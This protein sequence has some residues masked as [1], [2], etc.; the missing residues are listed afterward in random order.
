MQ[1]TIRIPVAN[2]YLTGDLFKPQTKP[3]AAFLACHG[4]TSSNK[5]YIELCRIL[6]K[7]EILA[8]AVNLRG[9]GDSPFKLEEFSRQNHLD[10][11]LAAYDFL[12]SQNGPGKK[13]F[14]LGKSYSGYLSA[15]AT[16]FRKIDYLILSHPALY[17]DREFNTSNVEFIKKEP[18]GFRNRKETVKC[19]RALKA[20][21]QYKNPVL[22]ILSEKDTEVPGEVTD[23]YIKSAQRNPSFLTN[24]I[25]KADHSLT[26][27]YWRQEFNEKVVR[28]VEISL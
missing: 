26:Q 7:K 12:K 9:H 21:S 10:D 2:Q 13:I 17:P 4:W 16:V 23:L 11:I 18:E 5:K 19:N 25:L 8:L 1:Q 6:S 28:W 27:P 20:I 22:I 14:L 15:I 24:I 3:K